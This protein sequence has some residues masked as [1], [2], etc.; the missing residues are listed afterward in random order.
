LSPQLFFKIHL[1]PLT[2]FHIS[3]ASK[4]FT[5]APLHLLLKP[6]STQALPKLLLGTTSHA[7]RNHLS[8]TT[9]HL[10]SHLLHQQALHLRTSALTPHE[11]TK[12]RQ[13]APLIFFHIS[14]TSKHFTHA[15]LHLPHTNQPVSANTSH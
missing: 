2:F 4:Y 10:F 7:R 1:A 5:Y 12:P 9:S 14:F 15:P 13:K 3:F 11:P 6:P 8:G